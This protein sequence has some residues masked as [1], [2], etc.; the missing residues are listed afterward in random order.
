MKWVRQMASA[1][2]RTTR[3]TGGWLL[4]FSA[5]SNTA[6]AKI[7]TPELDPGV[8]SSGLALLVGGVF[9]LSHRVRRK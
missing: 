1:L 6:Y 8:A 9:L 7:L 5:F 2:L 3:T 4:V